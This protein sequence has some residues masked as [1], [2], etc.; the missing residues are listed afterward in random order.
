MNYSS[1]P[2][3]RGRTREAHL[4]VALRLA[5]PRLRMA[6][7]AARGKK[8]LAES[9]YPEAIEQFTAALEASPTSPDY[10]VQRSIAYQRSKQ[11]SQALKDAEAAVIYAQKRAK[12]ELIVQAQLRRG[13]GLFNLERYGDAKFALDIVKRMDAKEKSVDMWLSKTAAK[14]AEAATDPVKAAVTIKETPEVDL[15]ETAAGKTNGGLTPS[16]SAN[17][18]VLQ[19]PADKIRH[20]WYQNSNRV[21]FTLLARGVPKDKASIEISATSLVISFPIEGTSSTYDFTID[22]LFASIDPAQSDYKILPTKIEVTLA[23]SAPG[24]KWSSLED[25]KDSVVSTAADS[26]HSD[27]A[28]NHTSSGAQQSGPAYPTSAR[29]GPKDWDKI[30]EEQNTSKDGLDDFDGGDDA[31]KFFKQLYKG[32][33]PETQRAMMKS[34]IESNGTALSTDWNEVKKKTVETL[35]P[36]GME[37]KSWSK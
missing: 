32:A 2:T 21:I 12:R 22:P 25:T 30:V 31:T 36:D 14:L 28:T 16:V 7:Q 6:D 10:L 13:I 19:T 26:A 17:T 1:T 33:S 3:L 4:G 11:Y 9:R 5:P 23:K 15:D 20:D 29:G 37:A 8:L 35:P 27:P 34:Y 18:Q 24:I